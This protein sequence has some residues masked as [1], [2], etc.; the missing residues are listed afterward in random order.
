[1]MKWIKIGFV[2]VVFILCIVVA[3]M[4]KQ[5]KLEQSGANLGLG[6]A[7]VLAGL[8]VLATLVLVVKNLMNNPK[9]AIRVGAGFL[10]MIVLYFIGKGMDAGELYPEYDVTSSVSTNV[11]GLLFVTYALGII[12]AVAFVAALVMSIIKK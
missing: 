12:S 10:V 9:G 11:G 4:T 6:L 3:V 8:G 7:Q 5:A 2:V 1:M